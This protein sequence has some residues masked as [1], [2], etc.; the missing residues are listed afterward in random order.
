[1]S[2]KDLSKEIASWANDNLEQQWQLRLL[3]Q[4]ARGELS[5]R[6]EISTI[7]DEAIQA[8]YP[9]SSLWFNPPETIESTDK[10]VLSE[11]DFGVRT[12]S[13]APVKLTQLKHESGVNRLKA[14]ATIDFDPSKLTVVFGSNGSGKS[15][16][17]RILKKFA[18]SRAIEDILPD[19]LLTD[20][21]PARATISFTQGEKKET[22]TWNQDQSSVE[23]AFQRVR[24]FDSRS[25][26]TQIRDAQEVAYVPPQIE[27]L[28]NFVEILAECK[29]LL[30]GKQLKQKASRFDPETQGGE[31]FSELV[32]KLGTSAGRKEIEQ[33]NEFTESQEKDLERLEKELSRLKAESPDRLIQRVNSRIDAIA[34]FERGLTTFDEV[35]RSFDDSRAARIRQQLDNAEKGYEKLKRSLGS[36]DRLQLTLSKDWPHL[37]EASRGFFSDLPDDHG[38]KHDTVSDWDACPVCQQDLSDSAKKRLLKFEEFAS[39]QASN[40]LNRAN[41][42]LQDAQ[43]QISRITLTSKE[44][45][46]REVTTLINQL[47]IEADDAAKLKQHYTAYCQAL[48]KEVSHLNGIMDG[49][50]DLPDESSDN[51][52]ETPTTFRSEYCS[53]FEVLTNTLTQIKNQLKKTKKSLE[54]TKDDENGA[55][56]L[57]SQIEDLKYLRLVAENK[58]RLCN[59]HDARL[60]SVSIQQ[61]IE[62][63][64]PTKV[65]NKVRKL[66]DNF[67]SNVEHRFAA[68]LSGLGFD[69][70]LHVSLK[71]DKAQKGVSYIRL[72]VN[73]DNKNKAQ[74][75]L[76]EGEQRIASLACFFADLTGLEDKSCLIF[77]D[78]VSSLDHRFRSKVAKRL[79]EESIERQVI[80]FSHDYTFVRLLEQ[81]LDE[82]NL[83]LKS[84]GRELLPS[85]D[86][87]EIFRT[88]AGAGDLYPVEW[89]RR[90]LS[91]QI[92]ALKQILQDI[93]ALERNDPD[94]Y[95]QAAR[96]LIGG[97]RETWER[98]VEENLL[99]GVIVR[100]D[101]AVHTQKLRGL[102]DITEE[103]LA[104]VDMGMTIT[105]RLMQGHAD[106]GAI[107]SEDFPNSKMIREEVERVEKFH[108]D[109]KN[110]RR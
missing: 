105:S 38:S 3:R 78:P 89:R 71:L 99:N 49:R 55:I 50:E 17:T 4:V 59:E 63:C 47:E 84:E 65:T 11:D 37:W 86:E 36:V 35:L 41:Q 103:D 64:K 90:S 62:N 92:G 108:K 60:M 67:I 14:G 2:S 87:K 20:P 93:E 96:S 40:D 15:G 53:S 100:L 102:T 88:S 85:I 24:V 57:A 10:L 76:S 16:Y 109:I 12:S 42:T 7:V 83:Y 25:A 77:D 70:T 74:E 32:K 28:T 30:E 107:A 80:V 58:D 91:K 9:E 54:T 104:K 45:A 52:G 29:A 33:I 56:S 101:K 44:D 51:D 73:A 69:N 22:A 46:E 23:G 94:Q 21:K 75:I 110:R 66:S 26:Q 68:E 6:K 39:S 106:S 81:A 48:R 19:I 43:N 8:A 5:S 34:N 82:V 95:P 72:K 27:I 97:I 79:V 13:D 1:M 61:A 31:K 98:E 18:A